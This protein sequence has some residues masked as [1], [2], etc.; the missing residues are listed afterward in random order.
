MD[1]AVGMR[2]KKLDADNPESIAAYRQ[3]RGTVV[4]LCVLDKSRV[5]VHWDCE[6]TPEP[7]YRAVYTVVPCQ[8]V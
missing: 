6:A 3:L 2:V 7:H 8:K 4:E 1:L 5:R